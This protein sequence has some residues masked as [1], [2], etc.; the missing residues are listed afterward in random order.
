MR[1][2][3]LVEG[4]GRIARIWPK[5]SVPGHAVEVLAAARQL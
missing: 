3:F 5:V 2:T 4:K 1:K